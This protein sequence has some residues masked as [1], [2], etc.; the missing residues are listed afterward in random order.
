MFWRKNNQKE[1]EKLEESLKVFLKPSFGLAANQKK[2]LKKQLM[3]K[4]NLMQ[5][6]D[7]YEEDVLSLVQYIQELVNGL[8]LPVAANAVLKKRVMR[9]VKNYEMPEG[10]FGLLQRPGYFR[11]VFASVLLVVMMFGTLVLM[12]FQTPVTF[13][14]KLTY[15]EEFYGQVYVLRNGQNLLAKQEFSL[16]EGDII[17]TKDK[18]FATIR[19][20][21]DSTSRLGQNTY[22]QL[23]KLYSEPLNNNSTQVEIA[24]NQGRLWT[25][26]LNLV[27]E[28]SHFIV[29]TAQGSV[30]A[31][32]KAVFDV[33]VQPMH[34]TLAV[35]DN[36]VDFSAK[37]SLPNQI[38]PIVAGFQADV[39]PDNLKTTYISRVAQ[40]GA[41]A[42][43]NLWV[44]SNLER[45]KEHSVK[46]ASEKEDQLNPV[47]SSTGTADVLS[48]SADL[49]NGKPF[50]NVDLERQRLA[51]I[52]NYKAL[53][54]GEK[55]LLQHQ[56]IDGMKLVF[57]F[58]SGV[59]SFMD[60]YTNLAKADAVNT[61]ILRTLMQSKIGQQYKDLVTFLPG[62]ILYP[63]KEVIE[64][65][66]LFLVQ[67][68]IDRA[69]ISLSQAEEKLL[70]IQGLLAKKDLAMAD[71][72]LRRYQNQIDDFVL[73]IDG[74]DFAKLKDTLS[75]IF[76][77][78][79]EQLK[80][81]VA[82][83]K[84]LSGPEQAKF[85]AQIRVIR[86]SVLDKLIAALQ[87]LP[88]AVPSNLIQELKDLSQMYL[89]QTVRDDESI[90]KLNKLLEMNDKGIQ[91]TTEE[92][93][94][95]KVPQNLGVVT[96]IEKQGA[97]KGTSSVPFSQMVITQPVLA[98]EAPVP[99]VNGE[100]ST[101]VPAQT[102]T[103]DNANTQ[104]VPAT[105]QII[106]TDPQTG[107]QSTQP[108]SDPNTQL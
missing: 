46:I 8:R 96:L 73:K 24:V 106:D 35:F 101:V 66:Q 77:K 75:S 39:S 23:R 52:E 97:D 44:K 82:I 79:I 99:A 17:I 58:R 62:D 65:T 5:R 69:L 48:A 50:A 22:I 47:A 85:L 14:S 20:F 72:V 80:V 3:Q 19:F 18:S 102:S 78:Q 30:T 61:E 12:P 64:A 34:S 87:K 21:D 7:C 33:Q 11:S 28:K 42:D 41:N 83:E 86:R 105:T 38:K 31:T 92:Q 9:A 100:G 93:A 88:Q 60:A 10:A 1:L 70:E 37:S 95:A 6:S 81:L 108:V 63:A 74:D 45:D 94:Q 51:F 27:D 15:I 32:K 13:A 49:D 71:R 57:Q 91:Q 84:L 107:L 67:N 55:L 76:D 104:E 56:D 29:D 59:Q 43:S 89:S 90:I 40:D 36:V 54:Q 103:V 68:N 25:K 4:V 53:L 98:H 26:V 16:R 2:S